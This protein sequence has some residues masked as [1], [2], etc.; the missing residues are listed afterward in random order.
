V[1]S[2]HLANAEAGGALPEAEPRKERH[3]PVPKRRAE[4]MPQI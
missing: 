3:E 2:H 4:N 1:L